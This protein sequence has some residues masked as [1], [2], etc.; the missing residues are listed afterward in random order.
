MRGDL[1]TRG[2]ASLAQELHDSRVM[3]IASQ[4]AHEHAVALGAEKAVTRKGV[5]AK[6]Q[7]YR[8][9][10]LE[11]TQV[12]GNPA[13]AEIG[14]HDFLMAVSLAHEL[15]GFGEGKLG[16]WQLVHGTVVERVR[17]H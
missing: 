6:P 16:K 13:Y 2:M 8:G 5:P 15:P 9:V 4:G 10:F 7:K 3:L 11:I 17:F 1:R 12:F 14:I